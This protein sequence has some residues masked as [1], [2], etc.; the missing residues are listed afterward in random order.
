MET[1]CVNSYK[2]SFLKNILSS[3]THS[4]VNIVLRG[5]TLLSKFFLIIYLA[6]VLDPDQLGIYGLFTASINYALYLCGLDFY[7][8][9]QREMLSLSPIDWGRIIRHQFIFYGLLYLII[10]PLLLL[11]F[12]S[13]LLPWQV[14]GW[15]YIILTFEHLSQELYRLLV[16]CERITLAHVILFFRGGAW[17]FAVVALFWIKPEMH[18]LTAIWVGWSIGVAI[19]ILIAL[20]GVHKVIGSMHWKGPIDWIW[21]RHG[22]KVAA[23]YLIGTLSLRGLFTFDRYLLD[24][25][26]GKSAVGVY[27]FFMSLVNSLQ[28]FADAGIVSKLYPRIVVA[29]RT[30]RYKEYRHHLKNMTAGIV[31]FIIC[32]STGLYITI[33][34]VFVFIGRQVYI[35]QVAILWVLLAAVAIYCLGLVPHYALYARGADRPIVISSI[36]SVL[37]FMSSII[38]LITITN[39]MIGVA[40]AVLVSV[41]CL[42][43]M[44]LLVYI[45]VESTE[46]K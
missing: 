25:H 23:Q 1:D 8:Y 15:F 6:K 41:S 3:A 16:V 20:F 32:F 21:I 11:V 36:I 26:F 22:I 44:K 42:S 45:K 27:S 35:E 34:P 29:Y 28:A 18:G 37:V 13:D 39:E 5:A 24:I 14:I 33:K 2:V 17:A 9:A 4:A 46:I 30:G 7:T 10:M 40:I 19:S 43:I 31:V 38:T 12:I